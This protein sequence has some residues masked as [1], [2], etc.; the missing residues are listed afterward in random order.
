MR[1]SMG[2][3][4]RDIKPANVI[5]DDRGRPRLIDFGLARR[6]DLE[7]DLTRDG[8]IVG[9]PA[10]MSPEQAIGLSRQAD[11]R[12]D[13]YSLGV[14]FYELLCGR[15]PQE[16][17][18]IRHRRPRG[19]R[20][21][22][23]PARICRACDR[24]NPPIPPASKRSAPRRCPRDR[25]TDIRPPGR[26]PTTLDQW[27]QRAGDRRGVDRRLVSLAVAHVAAGLC[28]SAVSVASPGLGGEN[29]PT[30]RVATACSR[31]SVAPL[32]IPSPVPAGPVAE[33]STKRPARR[34][35]S[36]PP[37][38]RPATDRHLATDRAKL[39]TTMLACATVTMSTES[40]K[41]PS[42]LQD[43]GRATA[44]QSG[45][46]EP[47]DAAAKPPAKAGI[48]IAR[49]A[50]RCELRRRPRRPRRHG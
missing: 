17:H 31:G 45:V 26:W 19:A 36:T 22:R 10:Y 14:I 47:C 48:G 7:S 4:H 40:T 28:S 38:R 43:I 37:A 8:A 6:S 3:V 2:V 21:A 46:T 1:I 39:H 5:I 23:T 11:E 27:L 42:T 49:R 34:S 25:P 15:R 35:T 12:S 29:T 20:P 44:E 30:G 13:V 16:T 9:T 50:R 41:K 24:S 18:G 33:R 32:G